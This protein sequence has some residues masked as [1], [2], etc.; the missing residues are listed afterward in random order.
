VRTFISIPLS[1]L[2]VFLAGFN[3]WIMLTSRGPT[4]RSRKVWTQI[5]RVCGYLFVALFV[6]FCYFMLLRI[7]SADE[8]SPRVVLHL[9]MPLIL[10][11]APGKDSCS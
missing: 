6:I 4:P 1:G 9:S 11:P 2:F 7:R 3:V 10:A 5:H 8:L